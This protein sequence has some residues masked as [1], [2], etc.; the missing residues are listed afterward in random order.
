MEN[1]RGRFILFLPVAMGATILIY[2][3]LSTEPPLWLGFISIGS[4]LLLLILL[5]RLPP[6]RFIFAMIL[7]GSLGFARAEWRTA[8]QPPLMNVPYGALTLS[9]RIASIDLLPENRR[10]TVYAAQIAGA[11]PFARA[12]RIRL[13][14][15]DATALS[16]GDFV[17]VRVLLFRQDRPAYPGGWDFGR[18]AFFQG[19]GASGF[20]LDDVKVVKQAPA[21][22]IRRDILNLRNRIAI[23]IMATLPLQTGAVAVTLLTGFQQIMP[24]AERQ[25]FVSAGLAH[26][27]AVAGLH[28]GIVMGLFFA[29]TRFVCS[30]PEL[31]LL[32]VNSKAVAAIVALAGGVAYAVLTGTHLPILRSLAMAS[33][34]TLG[35]LAGR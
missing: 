30:R 27:L 32:R 35:V 3:N 11:A 15:D 1:E 18:D 16:I 33:M 22:G 6:M 7:A 17:A 9:G 34:V 25:A 10:I 2:F 20:A 14:N 28:V 21:G 26:I 31:V 19:L 13:R 4:A 12:V 23:E 8:E 24:A 29:A 5:W